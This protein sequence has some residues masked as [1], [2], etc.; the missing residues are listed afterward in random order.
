M[1]WVKRKTN[2]ISRFPISYFSLSIFLSPLSQRYHKSFPF[3]PPRSPQCYHH[4]ISLS[5]VFC[6]LPLPDQQAPSLTRLLHFQYSKENKFIIGRQCQKPALQNTT[7]NQNNARQKDNNSAS[8]WVNLWFSLWI[9]VVDICEYNNTV[10]QA[11]HNN[12]RKS[13]K[14]EYM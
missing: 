3:P 13:S 8:E 6:Q 10:S 11:E 7:P 14:R 9:R 1:L 4:I 5:T 2:T 12:L